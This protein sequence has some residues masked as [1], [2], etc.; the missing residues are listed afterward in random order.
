MDQ[1]K[2]VN[3][4]SKNKRIRREKQKLFKKVNDKDQSTRKKQLKISLKM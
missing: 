3:Q 2:P 1:E 4:V